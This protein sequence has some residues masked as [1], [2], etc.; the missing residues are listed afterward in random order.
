MAYTIS[1]LAR[2]AGVGVET[3]RF[4]QRRGLLRDPRPS[5]VRSG[6]GQRHYGYDDIRRLR[7]VRAA[8][9]AGFI[10]DEIAELLAL[11]ASE[12]REL[13]RSMAQ[14]RIAHLDAEIERLERAR[15][16]LRRLANKC[17][18]AAAGPCPIIA[19]FD[20]PGAD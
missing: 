15:A 1:E 10:L 14:T 3:V 4:Y 11:D 16:S 5:L 9:D 13:A 20:D 12:D 2:A 17:A 7:F 6:T 18:G 19:A 8:K